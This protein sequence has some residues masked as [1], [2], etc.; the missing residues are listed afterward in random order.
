VLPRPDTQTFTKFA[1]SVGI[2]LLIAALVVPGLIL[3]DTGVLQI[4]RRELSSYTTAARTELER[5]QRIARTAGH[6]APFAGIFFLILGGGLIAYGAPRLKRQEDAGE[7]R[8]SAELA[9]L[10]SEIRP[11]SEAEQKER[12]QE[13]VEEELRTEPRSEPRSRTGVPPSSPAAGESR[14]EFMRLAIE[15]EKRVLD[16]IAKSAPPEYDFQQ[17]IVMRD[18]ASHRSSLA[19]DGLLVSRTDRLPDVV[20]EIKVA[21]ASLRNNSR[22]RIDEAAAI[23]M[24]YRAQVPRRAIT[25]LIIVATLPITAEDRAFVTHQASALRGDIRVSL[26]SLDEIS[27]L[28]IPPLP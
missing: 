8:S 24:R 22:N 15:V 16:Q 13:S 25:W 14:N 6:V 17:Q 9:K 7:E 4:S 1:L 23:L 5:R 18:P 19:L 10:R 20:V 26:V 2:F 11:Q 28:A 27:E 21:R 12:L 3:N